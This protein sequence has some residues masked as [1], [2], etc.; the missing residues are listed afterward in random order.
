MKF[1]SNLIRAAIEIDLAQCTEPQRAL[2]ARMYP[3]GPSDDQLERAYDQIQ[4]TL[5]KTAKK[6]IHS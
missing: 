3:D 1:A 6:E 5:I 4:R 2:F